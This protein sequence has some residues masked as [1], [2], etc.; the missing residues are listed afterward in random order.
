MRVRRGSSISMRGEGS[1][2]CS[3]YLMKVNHGVSGKNV[4]S[5]GLA[6]SDG[7]SERKER[8]ER[9]EVCFY[10]DTR[11]SNSTPFHEQL[12]NK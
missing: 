8:R 10:S 6:S 7:R 5:E 2:R 4:R 1:E 9:G 3:S 12:S 11:V